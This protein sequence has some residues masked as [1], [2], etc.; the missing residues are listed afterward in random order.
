MRYLREAFYDEYEVF[1]L[2]REEKALWLISRDDSIKEFPADPRNWLINRPTEPTTEMGLSQ[3]LTALKPALVHIQH[4]AH[5]PLSIFSLVKNLGVPH[6]ISFHDY[7]AITPHF[8]LQGVSNA[9]TLFEPETSKRIFGSDISG[10]L[11]ARLNSLRESFASITTKVVPSPYLERT[12][13]EFFAFEFTTIPY[14]IPRFVSA[15]KPP[16]QGALR[17]AT[18]GSILP[19][20]GIEFAV[21]AFASLNIPPDQAELHVYGGAGPE[22]IPG[23]TFHGA[24][25]PA[26]LPRILSKIDIGIVPSLF[27][28]TY[29]MVLSELWMARI[30]PCVSDIGA[31]GERV[32]DGENGKKFL[33]GNAKSFGDAVHWFLTHNSWRHWK[34]PAPRTVEEMTADYRALYLSLLKS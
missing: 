13:K 10:Y 7:Y 11:R 8:T 5:W 4:F 27:A 23:V 32:I 9:K 22:G 19:Q 31:M 1:V 25:E 24:Y 6:L 26:D 29:S 34:L 18:L 2:S 20:K 17:F 16:H 12:L 30:V 33:P 3:V 15:E 28:E 14:G 21:K